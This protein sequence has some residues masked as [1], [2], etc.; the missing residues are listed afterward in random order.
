MRF[1]IFNIFGLLIDYYVADWLVIQQESLIIILGKHTLT[2]V[3]PQGK[4]VEDALKGRS[5]R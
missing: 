5:F 4:Y 2:L 1:H 3:G